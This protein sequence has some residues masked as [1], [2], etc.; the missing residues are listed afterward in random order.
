[1][2]KLCRF[3]NKE[4]CDN[5]ECAF[6]HCEDFRK[7]NK[8]TK[9]TFL[10]CP[11]IPDHEMSEIRKS[12]DPTIK[13]LYSAIVDM[14]AD[15]EQL[16]D[17]I[18]LSLEREKRLAQC[19]SDQN[20]EIA[21]LKE[22]FQEEVENSAK[23][24]HCDVCQEKIAELERKNSLLIVDNRELQEAHVNTLSEVERLRGKNDKLQAFALEQ[25]CDCYDEYGAYRSAQCHR[26]YALGY[27]WQ[28]QPEDSGE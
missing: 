14:S 27:E 10:I 9:D 26:C 11:Y 22:D 24:V 6:V 2:Q 19:I 7:R 13:R 21:R 15:Y 23:H 28:L 5:E 12:Q 16:K 1:M 17:E 4:V 20:D 25:L 18:E 3:C 8:K